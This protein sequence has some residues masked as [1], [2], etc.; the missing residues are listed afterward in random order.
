[1][2]FLPIVFLLLA[3][4]VC[5]KKCTIDEKKYNQI[6]RELAERKQAAESQE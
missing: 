3:V 5:S 4:F 1:M 2:V 6:V